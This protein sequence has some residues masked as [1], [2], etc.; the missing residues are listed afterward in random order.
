MSRS[1]KSEE[2]TLRRLPS[3]GHYDIGTIKEIL[4]ASFMCHVAVNTP[5]GPICIPTAYGRIDDDIYLHGS[6]KSRLLDAVLREERSVVTVTLLDGIVL[7]RSVFHSSMNYRSVVLFGKGEEVTDSEEKMRALEAVTESI[8]SGRWEEA[9][10][11]TP[12]ELKATKVVRFPIT[13]GSAKIRTGPPG[14]NS[15]DYELDIW[16]GVVPLRTGYEQAVS[17]PRLKEGVAVAGSVT[18]ILGEQSS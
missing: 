16:A 13:E 8:W 14:D 4:D 2:S 5:N 15:E 3:R 18:K 9:R 12:N 7:A 10:L 1:I 6:V 11:P 17:D